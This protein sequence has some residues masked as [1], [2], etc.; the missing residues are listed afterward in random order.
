MDLIKFSD[1]MFKVNTAYSRSDLTVSTDT[2]SHSHDRKPNTVLYIRKIGKLWDF[3]K[4]IALL[5]LQYINRRKGQGSDIN[6]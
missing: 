4:N 1:G 6:N 2:H 3:F 5:K